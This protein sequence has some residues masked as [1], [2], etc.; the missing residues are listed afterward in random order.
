MKE[1]YFNTIAMY[2]REVSAWFDSSCWN[3]IGLHMYTNHL[4][5]AHLV[6]LYFHMRNNDYSLN[7]QALDKINLLTLDKVICFNSTL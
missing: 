6:I 4:F 7:F 3:W 2:S 1:K 5:F